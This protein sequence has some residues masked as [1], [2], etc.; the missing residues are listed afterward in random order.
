[1]KTEKILAEKIIQDYYTANIKTEV[2]LD[3]ILTPVIGEIL[4][5]VGRGNKELGIN[6]KMRLIAKEFPI[7]N[8]TGE[9]KSNYRNCNADYL[10]C[11]DESVYF[12]ELKTTQESLDKK[13]MENYRDYL[14]KCKDKPFSEVPGADFI[15]LLNH[16]SKTGYSQRN[17]D[18]PWGK[19]EKDDLKRVFEAVIRYPQYISTEGYNKKNM[20]PLGDWKKEKH[21]VDEAIKYLKNTKAVSSKKYLLTAGQMLDHMEDGNWWD[22]EIKLLYLMPASEDHQS[23]DCQNDLIIV[24]FQE[25]I[26]QAH[27]ICTETEKKGL[28]KYWEWVTE[29]LR[30]CFNKGCEQE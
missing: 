13:Q 14:E 8:A 16:V 1:M 28:K 12:V 15:E 11:D 2:I 27:V 21:H 20:I 6:G 23:E 25:I 9:N 29:I 4:T 10:M 17:E 5:A 22:Y 30:Q 19:A 7:L 3:T 24:T 18:K 26:D